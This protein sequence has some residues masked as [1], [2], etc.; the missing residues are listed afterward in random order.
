MHIVTQHRGGVPRG[1]VKNQKMIVSLPVS[2]MDGS[3]NRSA[4][5]MPT[6]NNNKEIQ[7]FKE[8]EIFQREMSNNHKDTENTSNSGFID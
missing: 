2:I 5:F 4:A 8:K 6:Q 3:L 1:A 7:S